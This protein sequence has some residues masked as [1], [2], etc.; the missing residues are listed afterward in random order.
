MLF[1]KAIC[2]GIIHKDVALTEGQ[3]AQLEP[4]QID[5]VLKLYERQ[6]LVK[7][8]DSYEAAVNFQ[9]KGI[10][11]LAQESIISLNP[12]AIFDKKRENIIG[13]VPHNPP[14]L[15]FAQHVP[16]P[17]DVPKV[18]EVKKPTPPKDKE[19]AITKV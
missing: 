5:Y 8:F 6:G 17:V 4:E 9:Y 11:A 16:I 13:T 19:L 1:V 15:D 3:I 12:E 2:G 7:S 14:T 18:E 10:A